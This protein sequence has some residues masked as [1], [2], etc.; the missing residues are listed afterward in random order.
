MAGK[1]IAALALAS[2]ATLTAGGARAY[3]L[4]GPSWTGARTGFAY[5]IPGRSA[6]FS[7]AFKAA[8]GDWNRKTPF[9][10]TP[11]NRTALPCNMN[12]VNGVGFSQ[13]ACGEGFGSATLAVTVYSYS[14]VNRFI[15]AGTV[16]NAAKRFGVYTGPLQGN[17]VDLRRVA[18]H[19]LG[20]ALGLAHETRPGVQAIMRPNVSNVQHP[21]PD[22]IA[23]VNALY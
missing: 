1:T 19:E 9:K 5:V 13:T 22:D 7:N 14:G 2:M 17:V 12:G 3:T 11:L 10:F 18:V 4:E 16:F 23:G 8:M 21:Q 20:H 15:H 6:A